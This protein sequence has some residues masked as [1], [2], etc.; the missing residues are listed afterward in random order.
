MTEVTDA[1]K[2]A[3]SVEESGSSLGIMENFREGLLLKVVEKNHKGDIRSLARKFLIYGAYAEIF[4]RDTG[5]N[6]GLSGSMHAFFSPFGIYPNNA[7][8]GGSATITAD[9]AC[10]LPGSRIGCPVSANGVSLSAW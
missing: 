9:P 2:N 4:A 3:G 6:R 10:G 1:T 5:F 8:V 7:I